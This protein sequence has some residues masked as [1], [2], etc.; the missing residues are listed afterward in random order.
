[1]RAIGWVFAVVLVRLRGLCNR[2]LRRRDWTGL[3][4]P[5][6]GCD[7][8]GPHDAHLAAGALRFL[9]GARRRQG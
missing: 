5:C 7:A 1:M 8:A 3:T 9:S 4:V 6:H 2:L